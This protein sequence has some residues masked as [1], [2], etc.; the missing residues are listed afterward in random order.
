MFF[1]KTKL[2]KLEQLLAE[3]QSALKKTEEFEAKIREKDTKI[4]QLTNFLN[5]LKTKTQE[6]QKFIDDLQKQVFY[7]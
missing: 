5:T 2:Q 1:L 4:G 6:K 7:F 3:N